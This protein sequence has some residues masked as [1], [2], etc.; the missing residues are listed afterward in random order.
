M[1]IYSLGH[2]EQSHVTLVSIP[3]NARFSFFS[4][5]SGGKHTAETIKENTILD[6][7]EIEEPVVTE[8]DNKHSFFFTPTTKGNRISL[9]PV[10]GKELKY[11]GHKIFE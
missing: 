1:P 7:H 4:L 3:G 9:T 8:C 6:I 10:V 2:L 11:N 5:F